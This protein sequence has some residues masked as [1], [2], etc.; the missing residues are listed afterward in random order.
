MKNITK[1]IV[2][3]MLGAVL[4]MSLVSCGTSDEPKDIWGSATYT[5]NTEIG[6][7]EKTI[8]VEV[9]AEEKSVEFTVHS[10]KETLGDALSEHNLISGDQGAYGLYVKEVNGIY[11]DYN[12]TKSYWAINKDGE[13]MMTGVDSAEIQDGDSYEF[14]YTKN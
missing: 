5:E 8:L 11:A 4:C 7:G 14:V 10:D 1:N 13:A 6:S 3:V 2:N 9:L 12:I